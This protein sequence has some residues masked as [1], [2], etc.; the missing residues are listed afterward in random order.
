MKTPS[1]FVAFMMTS[2]R[3]SIARRA[4][5]VSVEKYGLPV[6]AANSTTR[7]FSRCRTARR[8]MNGSATVRISM[9]VSTR[10]TAP[11]RS[12]ASDSASAFMT[13]ASMPMLS[14][15]ARSMPRALAAS[16]RKMLPPPMTT[17]TSTPSRCTSTTSCAIWSATGGSM[18]YERSPMSASPD[19]LSRTR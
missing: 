16:P 3:T 19:S 9:A 2:A 10:V 7:P 14:A 17:A 8:R 4:A 15:V 12:R 5:A 11:W 6:P 18:P 1:T 13:V